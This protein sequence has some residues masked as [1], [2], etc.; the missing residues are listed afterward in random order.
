M[1]TIIKHICIKCKLLKN[2]RAKKM[3][4]YCQGKNYHASH[5]EHLDEINIAYRIKN[6]EKLKTWNKKYYK[7]NKKEYNKKNHARSLKRYKEDVNYHLKRKTSSRIHFTLKNNKIKKIYK[8][9]KYLGCS[10]DFYN[11]YLESKFT[12]GMTQNNRHLWEIDHIK[13]LALFD[14]EKDIMIAFNFKNTQPLWNEDHKKKSIND[15][16]LIKKYN[17]SKGAKYKAINN[18]RKGA[19]M[20]DEIKNNK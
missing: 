11:K 9:V 3:C 19:K 5:K 6:K 1:K 2:I 13:A 17:I 7:D 16:I 20:P 4:S 12:K 10:Y 18:L 14:L 8:T 15:M